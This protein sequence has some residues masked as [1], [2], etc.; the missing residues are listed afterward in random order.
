MSDLKGGFL[1]PDHNVILNSRERLSV[2]GVKEII[3]FDEKSVNVKTVCGEM[4][5]DGE[6]IH[7]NILNVEKGELEI[8]GKFNG[9]NYYDTYEGDKK[10]LLS[11]IFK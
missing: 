9:I 2:T 10:T 7:I 5:I 8:N 11:R 1:K 4:S 6:N 3:N